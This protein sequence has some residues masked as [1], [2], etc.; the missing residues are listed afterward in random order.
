MEDIVKKNESPETLKTKVNELSSEYGRQIL[1][2]D[3]SV[4]V[5]PLRFSAIIPNTDTTRKK[6]SDSAVPPIRSDECELTIHDHLRH[7]ENLEGELDIPSGGFK[8][9]FIPYAA[10]N[11]KVQ[12]DDEGTSDSDSDSDSDVCLP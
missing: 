7:F 9:V 3:G 12:T 11:G 8:A 2:D 6:D 10:A 5:K 1:C 4:L